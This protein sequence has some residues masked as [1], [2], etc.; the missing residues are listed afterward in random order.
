[1]PPQSVLVIGASRGL[2]LALVKHYS[3][4][5]HPSNIF[6]TVRGSA[7]SDIFPKGVRV[8][9]SVDCSKED[10]G[11]KVVDGLQGA[12]V[13]LVAY[14]AGVL[15]PEADEL[16]MYTVCSIAPVFVVKS[17]LFASSLSP[18]AKIIFL[19]SEA[20]SITLRTES[21]GGG[22]FGHHGSKAAANMVGHLL[23]Y[24]L[25]ERGIPIAMIHPG[26]LK[27]DMT[28]NA[29]MEEF[30]DKMG[31]IT[32]E[33]A[34]KPLTDFV[35]KLDMRMTGKFWAPLGARGIG[36]AEEVLGKE[37]LDK[38]GPLEIPW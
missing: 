11:Q 24:D 30:Y 38:P 18:S 28:K 12:A 3:S 37:V 29:G 6:A 8:I 19:T 33:E 10:C 15:K 32:P 22:A 5:I 25:K 23:S 4:V 36:N 31:A 13:D 9:E 27:T 20:G 21:E 2:G 16:M 14:V 35:E 26:F 34:S 1:M 7:P 17:L